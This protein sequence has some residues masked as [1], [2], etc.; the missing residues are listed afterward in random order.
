[1]LMFPSSKR[2]DDV[3]ERAWAGD[4]L[5]V[6]DGGFWGV[7]VSPEDSKLA[8]RRYVVTSGWGHTSDLEREGV[9][10]SIEYQNSATLTQV[11]VSHPVS[12]PL[13]T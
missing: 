8:M 1:M 4:D 7:F 5:G 12:A 10:R 9:E 2:E 13:D 3:L 11:T 6:V